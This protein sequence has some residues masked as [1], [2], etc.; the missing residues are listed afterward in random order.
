MVTVPMVVNP[1]MAAPQLVQGASPLPGSM[2]PSNAHSV[3]YLDENRQVLLWHSVPH[4]IVGGIV[5]HIHFIFNENLT[6]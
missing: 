6:Q 1:E 4:L 3:N 2:L 5:A